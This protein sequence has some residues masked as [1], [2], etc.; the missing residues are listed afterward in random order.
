MRS[1]CRVRG[2]GGTGGSS[3]VRWRARVGS[4]P[5]LTCTGC[6]GWGVEG[7]GQSLNWG[8]C[9]TCCFSSG[10]WCSRCH[11]RLCCRGWWGARPLA[12]YTVCGGQIFRDQE[13]ELEIFDLSIHLSIHL[14]S[15]PII[16]ATIQLSIHKSAYD[17]MYLSYLPAYLPYHSKYLSYLPYL[18]PYLPYHSRYLSYLPTERLVYLITSILTLPHQISEL[19][20]PL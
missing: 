12:S 17:L 9:S 1:P 5:P 18:S 7:R 3:C 14:F 6:V 2:A 10:W 20:T 15:N 11:T 13:L 8:P 19:S 4:S 16:Y